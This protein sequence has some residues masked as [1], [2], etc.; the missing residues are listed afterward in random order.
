MGSQGDFL[1]SRALVQDP[2]GCHWHKVERGGEDGLEKG[3]QWDVWDIIRH[4][5]EPVVVGAR[6][7]GGC[8]VVQMQITTVGR[9]GWEWCVYCDFSGLGCYVVQGHCAKNDSVYKH[10]C[11]TRIEQ[12]DIGPCSFRFLLGT[13][14]IPLEIL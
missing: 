8:M 6:V 1:G 2:G 14:W 5:T 12:Y 11:R 4:I 10:N 13:V 9:W 3:F 7:K